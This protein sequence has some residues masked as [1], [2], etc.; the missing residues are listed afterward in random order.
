MPTF[1][2]LPTPAF[3][4][5]LGKIEKIDHSGHRRILD[6]IARLLEKPEDADGWMHGVHHGR[7]KKYVGRSGYRLIYHWCEACRKEGIK[8]AAA[9]SFCPEVAD[10]TV[11]FFDLYHKNE[12]DRI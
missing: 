10:H 3:A 1:T 2:Y 6:V 5:K 7:L 8:M 12:A 4:A 9:C 11:I